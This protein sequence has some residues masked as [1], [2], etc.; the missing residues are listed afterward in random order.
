MINSGKADKMGWAF[1][2]GLER[3]AMV[4][5]SIPDIRLFWSTDPR[6]LSQF[7][8]GRI[9]PF[10]SYSK[11]PPCYKDVSFWIPEANGEGEG[12]PY[13]ENYVF[14]VTSHSLHHAYM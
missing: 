11:Y 14:E 1:G 8:D 3:L 9:N 7:Q 2:L 13:H 12:D 5:F 4:L 10:Q 6:F